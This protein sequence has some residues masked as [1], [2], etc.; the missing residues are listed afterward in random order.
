MIAHRR[1]ALDDN[2]AGQILLIVGSIES[3]CRCVGAT[4]TYFDATV[5]L[6]RDLSEQFGMPEG[7]QGWLNDVFVVVLIMV[8]FHSI[9]ILSAE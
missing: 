7:R 2:E 1:E 4:S 5:A 3:I 8:V 9:G 6:D